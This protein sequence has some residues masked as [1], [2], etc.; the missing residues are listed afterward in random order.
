MNV[1]RRLK[2]PVAQ[3]G[4]IAIPMVLKEEPVANVARYER[5]RTLIVEANDVA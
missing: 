1:L 4:L 5:L 3:D 2:E